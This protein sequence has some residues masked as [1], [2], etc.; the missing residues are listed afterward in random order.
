MKIGQGYM[1]PLNIQTFHSTPHS[2]VTGPV[3][4]HAYSKYRAFTSTPNSAVTGPVDIHA[5]S[6]YRA[7]TRLLLAVTWLLRLLEVEPATGIV[8]LFWFN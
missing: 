1:S 5:S 7:F 3:D 4:I 6:K 2:A 8:L